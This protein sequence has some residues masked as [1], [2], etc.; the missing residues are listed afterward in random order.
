MGVRR[1]D[2]LTLFRGQKYSLPN[3]FENLLPEGW[4]FRVAKSMKNIPL[5]SKLDMLAHLCLDTMGAVSFEVEGTE[6]HRGRSFDEQISWPAEQEE[7]K[8]GSLYC[9]YCG[10]RLA[11]RG[12]NGG[13]HEACSIEFFGSPRPPIVDVDRKNLEETARRQLSQGTSVPDA[14]EKFSMRYSTGDK[15]ILM[16]GFHYIIKPRLTIITSDN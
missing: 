3:Y 2:G 6:E 10:M 4:L 1:K 9:G 14:Q 5:N 15:T 13:F 16:P 11:R 7:N 12:L 8:S